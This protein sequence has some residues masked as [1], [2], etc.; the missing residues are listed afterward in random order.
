VCCTT[1]RAIA[2]PV[3]VMLRRSPFSSVRLQQLVTFHYTQFSG[4]S[5]LRMKRSTLRQAERNR[6]SVA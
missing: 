2:D 4:S 6:V 5:F 3:V 1:A